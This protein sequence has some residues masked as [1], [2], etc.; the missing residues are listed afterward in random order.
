MARASDTAQS[1]TARSP[2]FA[3]VQQ[4][5]HSILDGFAGLAAIGLILLRDDP[6]QAPT[7][8]AK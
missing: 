7:E 2:T 3:A 4:H 5:S 1:S 8:D 6:R